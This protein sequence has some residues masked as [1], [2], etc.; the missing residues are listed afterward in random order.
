MLITHFTSGTVYLDWSQL[1]YVL[2]EF[3]HTPVLQRYFITSG[4][5]GSYTTIF[6]S[7]WFDF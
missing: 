3:H 6:F 5:P 1:H 2:Y 4:L 7:H